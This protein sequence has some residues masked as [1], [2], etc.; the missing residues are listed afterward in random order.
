MATTLEISCPHHGVIEKIEVPDH[1]KKISFTGEVRCGNAGD[2]LP[3][4]IQIVQGH[5]ISVERAAP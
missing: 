1:Y 2:R 3:I 5:V 4:K